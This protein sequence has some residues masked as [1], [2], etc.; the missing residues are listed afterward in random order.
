M[1]QPNNI[2]IEQINKESYP[3]PELYQI[4]SF[5]QYKHFIDISIK[6]WEQMNS[7][8]TFF[9]SANTAILTALSYVILEKIKFNIIIMLAPTVAAILFCIQWLLIIRSLQ[10][11]NRA[12]MI[13]I[14]EMESFLPF[15]PY[16]IEWKRLNEKGQRYIRIQILYMI[17]PVSTML[18]YLSL[19]LYMLIR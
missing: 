13:T 15:Q 1:N 10:K 17:M 7:V 19:L 14:Q 16:T 3:S 6:Y 2:G 9:I 18:I 11:T 12:R 5:E 4:H 8:N